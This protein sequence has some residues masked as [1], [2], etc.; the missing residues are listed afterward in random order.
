MAEIPVVDFSCFNSFDGASFVESNTQINDLAKEIYDAFSTIGFVYIK[1]HGIPT[2]KVTKL[3][4]VAER[5]FKLPTKTKQPFATEFSVTNYHGWMAAG[6][7]I[8]D[9]DEPYDLKEAFDI[10]RPYDDDIPWP[11]GNCSDFQEI[12]KDFFQCCEKLS[13][14]ILDLIAHGLKLDDRKIF[15]KTHGKFGTPD[16]KTSL[17]LLYYPF[18]ADLEAGQIRLGQHSDYG[19]ITL[20]FQDQIGGLEVFSQKEG[21]VPARPIEETILV[22]IGDLLQRWTND[23]LVSTRHRVVV[24]QDELLRLKSRQSA[25]FFVLPE[26]TTMVECLDGSNKYPPVTALDYLNQRLGDTYLY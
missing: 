16:N 5:F 12:T 11:T 14:G 18:N 23:K 24:P 4:E 6:R 7:E 8:V 15:R 22:N 20:L 10:V 21:F 13:H 26:N 17:R 3:F 1:N 25:A 2:E 9:P 19:T